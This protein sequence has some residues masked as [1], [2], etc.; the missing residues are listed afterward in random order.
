MGWDDIPFVL[1][2]EAKRNL[3]I[4]KMQIFIYYFY[5]KINHINDDEAN[6]IESI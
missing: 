3:I 5:V 2:K 4:N 1:K 6:Y